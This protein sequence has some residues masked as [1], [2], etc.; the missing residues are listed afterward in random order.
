[1]SDYKQTIIRIDDKDYCLRMRSCAALEQRKDAKKQ[2][3]CSMKNERGVRL[4]TQDVWE[5]LGINH[6]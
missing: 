2:P 6:N 4:N 5:Y 3:V 1:M